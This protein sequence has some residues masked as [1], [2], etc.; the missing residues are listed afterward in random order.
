ML[1]EILHECTAFEFAGAMTKQ[2][3]EEAVAEVAQEVVDDEDVPITINAPAQP[4]EPGH[5]RTPSDRIMSGEQPVD[6]NPQCYRLARLVLEPEAQAKGDFAHATVSRS[7]VNCASPRLG[8]VSMPLR[9]CQAIVIVLH[10]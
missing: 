10:F 9:L 1:E 4:S 3:T 5:K 6:P 2:V 7:A 8:T